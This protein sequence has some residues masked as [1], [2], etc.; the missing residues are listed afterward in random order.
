MSQKKP[1]RRRLIRLSNDAE[2]LTQR[3]EILRDD[4]QWSG[5]RSWDR[6]HYEAGLMMEF[7][8]DVRGY[9]LGTVIPDSITREDT[10]AAML[11]WHRGR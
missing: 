11:E 8:L 7:L 4:D 2:T 1:L 3:I 9:D 6:I 10:Y 5:S